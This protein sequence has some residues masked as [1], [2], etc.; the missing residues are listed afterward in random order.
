MMDIISAPPEAQDFFGTKAETR[1]P[2]ITRIGCPLLAFF[3]TRDDVGGEAEL[4]LLKASLARQSSGPRHVDTAM[5]KK[6]DHMYTGE[7]GQV[8]QTILEWTSGVVAAAFN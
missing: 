2:G 8:A 4:Q 6:A 1:N 3:G 5:I 7:E